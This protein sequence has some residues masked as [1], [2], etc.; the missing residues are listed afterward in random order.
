MRSNKD[1]SKKDFEKDVKSEKGLVKPL[2]DL[3]KKKT[4]PKKGGVTKAMVTPNLSDT[5]SA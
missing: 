4:P 5:D 1:I 3:L 2:E